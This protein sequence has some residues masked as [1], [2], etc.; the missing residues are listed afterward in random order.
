MAVGDGGGG[1]SGVAVAADWGARGRRTR[2]RATGVG[3]EAANVS[4]RERVGVQGK[5]HELVRVSA[6]EDDCPSRTCPCRP[7]PARASGRLGGSPSQ[8]FLRDALQYPSQIPC[9]PCPHSQRSSWEDFCFCSS[10]C[11]CSNCA[12][13]LLAPRTSRSVLP[14]QTYQSSSPSLVLLL[15]SPALLSRRRPCPFAQTC[16]PLPPRLPRA[17]SCPRRP[18][19][20]PSLVPR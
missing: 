9:S 6:C 20:R 4:F 11:S 19:E 7:S 2:G 12:S 15:S 10:T 17:R 3:C 8:C 5:T 1:S 18:L 14:S 16:C 13:S